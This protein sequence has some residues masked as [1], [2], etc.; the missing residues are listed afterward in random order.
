MRPV[1]EMQK[2]KDT[3]RNPDND[4]LIAIRTDHPRRRSAIWIYVCGQIRKLFIYS[5]F[6]R[7]PFK[8]FGAT[9]CRNLP[10]A[11]DLAIGLIYTVNNNSLY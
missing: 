5:K 9:E 6:H 2:Q 10:S 1:D 7:N 11:I 8:G 4:K 3:D